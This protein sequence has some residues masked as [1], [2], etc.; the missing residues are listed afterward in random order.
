MEK[1]LSY[2]FTILVAILGAG[3]YFVIRKLLSGLSPCPRDDN[4]TDSS[5]RPDRGRTEPAKD[6]IAESIRLS[7]ENKRAELDLDSTKSELDAGY[8]RLESLLRKAR[9]SG[10]I[11]ESGGLDSRG[12]DGNTD[13]P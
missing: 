13:V 7:E 2:I 5:T 12:S 3:G 6:S 4:N 1:I 8:T 11:T 10:K 9:E